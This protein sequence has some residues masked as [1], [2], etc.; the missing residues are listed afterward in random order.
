VLLGSLAALTFTATRRVQLLYVRHPGDTRL[1]LLY[2]I[3]LGAAGLIAMLTIHHLFDNL[4]V[5]GMVA[6]IGLVVV[7]AAAAHHI[8]LGERWNTH[9]YLKTRS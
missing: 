4:Y 3:A 8:A 9:N 6:L 1:S 2:G 7:L 5:H